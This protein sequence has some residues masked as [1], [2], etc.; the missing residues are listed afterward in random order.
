M[1]DPNTVKK[2]LRVVLIVAICGAVFF[3]GLIFGVNVAYELFGRGKAMQEFTTQWRPIGKPAKELENLLGKP[4]ERTEEH[5]GYRFD[6]GRSGWNWVF[7]LSGETI[8][9]FYRNRIN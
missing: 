1:E 5:L 7:Q 2:R 8:T 9:N 4:D 6:T 3:D